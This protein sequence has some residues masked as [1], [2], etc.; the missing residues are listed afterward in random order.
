MGG[1]ATGTYTGSGTQA[2]VGAG[3]SLLGLL[4]DAY[5]QDQ[6]ADAM[7]GELRTERD[8]QQGYD[9]QIQRLLDLLI[10]QIA[11]GQDLAQQIGVARTAM[12]NKAAGR[13]MPGLL[14]GGLNAGTIL[15]TGLGM[16]DR[17]RRL[18]DTGQR[19][20]LAQLAGARS[21]QTLEPR[22]QAAGMAGSGLRTGGQIAGA[23]GMNQLTDYMFADPPAAARPL[24]TATNQAVNRRLA[25]TLDPRNDFVPGG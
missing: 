24:P 5:G 10:P 7:L 11:G 12:A 14:T 15:G 19:V 23:Y 18:M 17:E 3:L 1:G 13:G 2:G 6:G 22:L 21:A 20:N 8:R 9:G 16:K 25:V 4:A